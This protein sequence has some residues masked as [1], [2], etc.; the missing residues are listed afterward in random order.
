MRTTPLALVRRRVL[1]RWLEGIE[2]P[3]TAHR[4]SSPGQRVLAELDQRGP[5]FFDE[6][7]ERTG[8]L[9][10]QVEGALAERSKEFTESITEAV[11]T[12]QSTTGDL[13][14][15]V[16]RLRDVSQEILDGVG[17]VVE[18][19]AEQS[20][21]LES[22]SQ[23]LGEVNQQIGKAIEDAKPEGG[24]SD[25]NAGGGAGDG[26]DKPSPAMLKLQR[27]LFLSRL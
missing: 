4:L 24:D 19:F 20:Q 26:D 13:G 5:S 1:A 2:R 27:E 14:D 21:S 6:I 12:T 17:G 15:Q 22:A 7:E 25:P 10:S 16:S 3:R 9:R 11:S 23:N 8:L 18:R